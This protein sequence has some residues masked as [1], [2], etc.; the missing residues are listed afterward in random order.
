MSDVSKAY[1]QDVHEPNRKECS[2]LRRRHAGKKL[3]GG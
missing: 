1:E 3:K 2:N